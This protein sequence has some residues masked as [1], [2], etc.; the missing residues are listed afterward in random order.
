MEKTD[1]QLERMSPKLSLLE[2]TDWREFEDLVASYFRKIYQSAENSLMEVEVKHSGIGADGGRDMLITFRFFDSIVPFNR[3]WVV[4]CKFYDKPVPK[5][6]LADVNI[7]SLIHEYK[8]DGYLLICKMGVTAGV[9]NMFE[10]LNLNCR[11]GYSYVYWTG[12]ELI[13]KIRVIPDIVTQYFPKYARFFEEKE[14]KI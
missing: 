3:R 8:A 4:Q 6:K 10:N 13:E 9:S 12:N 14:K 2:I 1:S 7:P 11:F 5:T